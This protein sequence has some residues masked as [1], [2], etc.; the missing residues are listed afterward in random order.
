MDEEL[1]NGL[2]T[3][4]TYE[5]PSE[6]KYAISADLIRGHINTIILR[7]LDERDK[8]GYEIIDEIEAK[9]HGQ[10]TL[11]QPTLYSALKRL[12]TQGYIK[13]YW[14]TDEVTSGGR[15]KYFT[16]TELG[17]EF[18]E[19]NQS[20]W[21]YSRTVIDSLISDKPFD[22]SKPAPTDVDFN[23]LKKSVTRV[24]TGD[25]AEEGEKPTP[26]QAER[27]A[28]ADYRR[29][30]VETLTT[31]PVKS[32]YSQQT[33]A[34]VLIDKAQDNSSNAP[35]PSNSSNERSEEERRITH[36]NFLKLISSAPSAPV[37]NKPKD[38][39]IVPHSE[40][41]DTEKLIYN[42]KPETE[43]DYKKLV[44]LI[45]NKAIK[46]PSQSSM[47]QTV[48]QPHAQQTYERQAYS[49]PQRV[50]PIVEKGKLDGLNVKSST[51]S[52]TKNPVKTSYNVGST[53]FCSSAIVGVLFLLEFALCLIFKDA[54]QI[55]VTYPLVILAIGI[56][57]FAIFGT[58]ALGGFGKGSTKPTQHNYIA[59]SIILT[60]IAI[61][62]I[63]LVGFLL[64]VNVQSVPDVLTKLVIPSVIALNVPVFAISFYFIV[65]NR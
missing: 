52:G 2:D 6:G 13:A 55:T 54:L 28:Q 59:V 27:N 49:Q 53:L 44:N 51:S 30:Y 25:K 39:N 64:N 4:P 7:T 12:E 43:R 40:E 62:I 16:L 36:E 5:Q 32:E 57:Q 8:Y 65:R 19:K 63:C 46:D 60:I 21:E 18:S 3:E 37:N 15:R 22:F 17:R 10:Y 33:T 9:S 35:T 47:N 48:Q 34:E 45:F 11:K 58:L 29:A 20:E 38:D 56:A 41:I 31:S 50:D 1:D 61:L 26:E 42:N 24:P 14:K 23:L